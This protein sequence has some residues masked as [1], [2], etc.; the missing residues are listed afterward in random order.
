MTDLVVAETVNFIQ[1]ELGR[2]RGADRAREAAVA[3][4]R[5][6]V[7]SWRT[8]VEPPTAEDV[9]ASLEEQGAFGDP[10]VSFADCA[11]FVIMRRLRISTAFTFDRRHFGAAGFSV[12]P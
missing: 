8:R 7:L 10:K 12:I 11:S 1:R 3:E 2:A 6:I 4:G 9:L 5:K